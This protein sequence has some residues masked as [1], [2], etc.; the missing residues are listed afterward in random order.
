MEKPGKIKTTENNRY[1]LWGLIAVE[2]FMSF[3]F[4]GYIHMDPI[5]LTFVYIPV[6]VAG[7]ILGPKESTLIGAVFGLASMWKASAFYVGA[8]DAIF[9]PVMS[10]KLLQSVLLSVG[11]R[12]LFGFLIGL[13]YQLAKKSRHP[14]AGI[15]LV[16]SI[17]RTL[18]SFLVYS[19]MGVLFPETG[20]SYRN[21]LDD[22]LQW[23]F[24][25][26][27]LIVDVIV[28]LC[29]MA[30]RSAYIQ[31]LWYRVRTVDQISGLVT[32]HNKKSLAVMLFLV[33]LSSFSV[34]YYFTNRIESIMIRYEINLSANIS[35]DLLHLQIQF[36]LGMI[37][38]A[39]IVILV[40]ILYQKNFSY[41]NYEARMDELTGHL[42]RGQFFQMG[43]QILDN[44]KFD[45]NQNEKADCFIIM[46]VDHFK[47][48]NDSY[49][50]P[51]GD[52]GLKA[53]ADNLRKVLGDQALLGRLGGDEF[54]ALMHQALSRQE[55]ETLLNRLKEENGKIEVQ[56]R[57]VTCSIGVIP[58][59]EDKTV[60]DLYRSAD[61][62]LYEAKKKGKN[63]FVFEK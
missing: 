22:T 34:A 9:S 43:Q 21:T 60:E 4:M 3:S 14:M 47:E 12:A 56:D 27:L 57:K 35:Y 38:L 62:M 8:G 17:G 42:G 11:A 40:I 48:I 51:A 59:A 41:L 25:P 1:L 30:R 19:F 2:L 54:V 31:R 36:L 28:V 5:L 33:L 6:L 18:H 23:D 52:K 50:H 49:G 32:H 15:I 20:F 39:M 10:G 58:L 44:R 24:L 53:V 45:H 16:T 46:D 26:F 55:V 13:L 7:C 37:S 29:D 61:R 63:Q